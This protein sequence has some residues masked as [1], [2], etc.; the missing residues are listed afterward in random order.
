MKLLLPKPLFLYMAAL[1]TGCL[2]GVAGCGQPVQPDVAYLAFGDSSTAGASEL[3]YVDYLPELLGVPDDALA[4][5][6]SG[7][8]G[9]A[10]GLERLVLLFD[11]QIFPNAAVLLYWQGGNDVVDFVTAADPLLLQSPADPGYPNHEALQAV[12]DE[13]ET[14]IRVA[15]RMARDAGLDVLV[16]TY[17]FMPQLSLNCDALLLD[18]LL[19]FQAV[20]A[21]DY[22]VMLNERIRQAAADEGAA[23]V[24]VAA[25]DDVLRA[26]P[27]N[28]ENCNH[29]SDRGNEI[30]AEL[31]ADAIAGGS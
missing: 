10:D 17:Y 27:D 15:I 24:D 9:T 2:G 26:D 12:L 30:V 14:N 28:Y 20:N 1:C 13:T 6:G 25:L 21:N 7:G 19:P 4:N 22:T 29:L 5:E 23:V 8:E 11:Q 18:L 31:F 16:A 3:S